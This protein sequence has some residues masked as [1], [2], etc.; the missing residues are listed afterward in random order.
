MS[1]LELDSITKVYDDSSGTIVAV[2]ELDLDID[3]G[4]LIVFVGPSGC[5]KSTTL[6]MIAGLENVTDGEIKLDGEVINNKAPKDRDIAMV[7]QSY[8]LY[9][10]KT[11]RQ[12]MAYGLKLGTDLTDAE[13]D[14]RVTDATEM[15][16]INDLLDKKPGSLS[17]GQRQR[18][19][20]GRAIVR[21]PAVFL[22]DEPLSNLDAKLRK[23]MRTELAEIHNELEITTIYVT[24]DQEE[25]M[26]LADR[27]AILDEGKLQQIGRPKQV[28]SEPANLFVADFIGS[29]SLNFFDI[30]VSDSALELVNGDDRP[31]YGISNELLD[32]IEDADTDEY[33]LG[34]RPEDVRLGDDVSDAK[35]VD[36]TV[37]VV[38]VVGSDNFIYLD[39]GGEE[40]RF[41]AD[42]DIE[43]DI[44]ETLA[45]TFDE[46]DLHIFNRET[47]NA[48][49]HGLSVAEDA[50]PNVTESLTVES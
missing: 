18:V 16:G 43:P 13:I 36:G 20:T 4:E 25:A 44:D 23:H 11:V 31:T 9:P 45:V 24:H 39:T 26:T 3:D 2:E 21:E 27:I 33:V 1:E 47:G 40:F 29:P 38:E 17:G 14:K 46:T 30:E 32:I 22:F 12:N 42:S 5:G 8:A 19:A 37:K 35:T 34:F 28:Y 50:T 6:R 48:I 15:M 10:H 41:R 7:F 49:A